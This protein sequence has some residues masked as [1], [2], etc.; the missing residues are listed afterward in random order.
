MIALYAESM[1]SPYR[2]DFFLKETSPFLNFLDIA[3]AME[4]AEQN[5]TD[6]RQLPRDQAVN[7]LS[8]HATAHKPNSTPDR[9]RKKP[10]YSCLGQHLESECRFRQAECYNCHKKGHIRRA[11]KSKSQGRGSHSKRRGKHGGPHKTHQINQ[12]GT[13]KPAEPTVYELFQTRRN[14][15]HTPPITVNLCMNDKLVEMEVDTGASASLISE[16]TL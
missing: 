8:P 2:R 4:K 14:K 12:D 1:M 11:C 10:C 13:D 15:P 7:H 9:G 3:L 16:K 5:S 6:V